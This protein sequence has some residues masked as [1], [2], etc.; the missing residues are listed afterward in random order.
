MDESKEQE[1]MDEG[2]GKLEMEKLIPDI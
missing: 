2:I 1:V